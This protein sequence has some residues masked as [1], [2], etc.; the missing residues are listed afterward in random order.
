MKRVVRP[1]GHLFVATPNPLRLRDM[2]A[3]R[4]LGDFIRRDGYPWATPPW[5]L[6]AMFA[7]CE[8]VPIESWVTGRCLARAG[9]PAPN[10]PRSVAQT[11]SLVQAWQKW[12]VR[13]PSRRVAP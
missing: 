2:H 5:R 12:L 3:K 7:D 11:A 10:V 4:W 1:G 6:R 9:L 8:R 13:K